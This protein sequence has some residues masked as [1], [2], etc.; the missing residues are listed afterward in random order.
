MI[1]LS[2]SLCLQAPEL[3]P[4]VMPGGT[5]FGFAVQPSCKFFMLDLWDESTIHTS[6]NRVLGTKKV[7]LREIRTADSTP[8]A[9][10]SSPL[11]G[12]VIFDAN[13]INFDVK[14]IIV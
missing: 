14:F 9:Y 4:Y 12:F 3:V 8:Q 13:F 11:G 10:E 6:F 7:P 2:L 5:D 1:D